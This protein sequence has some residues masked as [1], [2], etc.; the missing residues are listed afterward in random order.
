MSF[1]VFM[2]VNIEKDFMTTYILI[3]NFDLRD[4]KLI[5]IRHGRHQKENVSMEP[6]RVI[7]VLA[8]FHFQFYFRNFPS[9]KNSLVQ[10]QEF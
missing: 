10:I 9:Q 3:H 2:I 8:E 7:A 6:F 5:I 4:V 1:H